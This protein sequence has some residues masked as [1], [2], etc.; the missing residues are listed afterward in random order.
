MTPAGTNPKI[1][2]LRFKVKTDPKSRL[3]Y[4]LA[5]ELRKIGQPA[6]AEAV[7]RAGLASHPTY[8]S[9]WV[10]L[11]RVLRE[12]QKH[13]E[14]IEPL[15]KALELDRG[16]VVAARLL[17]E[18]YLELGEKVEAIKKYK[19]VHALLPG[20]DEIEATI[21]RLEVELNSAPAAPVALSAPPVEEEPAAVP[22]AGDAADADADADVFETTYSR[23]Q[24]EAKLEIETGDAEPMS[25]AHAD[26]PFEEPAADAGYSADALAV[27][28]P[29]GIHLTASPLEA[30]LPSP[31]P[32]P[33][34]PAESS[35]VVSP[36][37][38]SEADVDEPAGLGVA[39]GF[40]QGSFGANV[41]PPPLDEDVFART[42][43][44]AD[45]YASQ[46]LYDEA[47][48]IYEDILARDP[49]NARVLA[50]LN[51]LDR[52]AA[53]PADAGP[54]EADD[55]ATLE[56]R[57]GMTYTPS[58]E[59]ELEAAPETHQAEQAVASSAF[60]EQVFDAEPRDLEAPVAPEPEPVTAAAPRP[61]VSSARPEV[62]KLQSWLAKVKRT[63]AGGV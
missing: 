57:S 35:A 43:T 22:E 2:E 1:E 53:A 8:L 34:I 29:S 12:Q 61:D 39:P 4:P 18:S 15:M 41:A 23:L 60:D 31:L 36:Q 50:K 51:D 62:E 20:D 26:S 24:R 45:L 37:S 52:A 46:G 28:N 10:V 14:S 30:D 40:I 63:G 56:L 54:T 25:A 49:N 48:D 32:P 11:G 13:Q 6:E 47:R 42:I 19:L 21:H 59:S 58:D 44:M 9:A 17:A 55:D 3:F 33:R 7:L 16:N 27:E 5:E 38:E